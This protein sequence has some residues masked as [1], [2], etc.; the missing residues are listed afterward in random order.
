[1][2]AELFENGFTCDAIV[3]VSAGACNAL[4]M[5]IDPT[6][7]GAANLCEVW[8]SLEVADVFPTTKRAQFAGLIT[9]GKGATRQENFRREIK[10]HLNIEDLRE[11][12]IPVHIGTVDVHTGESIWFDRGP[13][14]EILLA[15]AALPGVFPPVVIDGRSL[16]DGGVAHV[17][18]VTKAL[19]LQPRALVALDVTKS[20]SATPLGSQITTLRRGIDH[21]REALRRAQL[22]TVPEHVPFALVRSTEAPFVSLRDEVEAGRQALRQHLLTHPLR[23]VGCREGGSQEGGSREATSEESLLPRWWKKKRRFSVA[24]VR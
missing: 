19:E 11:C 7:Q 23:E 10:T 13:A 1:M 8:N 22:A 24:G 2:I 14:L 20:A 17:I 18:P 6:A 3:G 5:G 9:Q 12:T 4:Y 15:S 16:Y 21:T